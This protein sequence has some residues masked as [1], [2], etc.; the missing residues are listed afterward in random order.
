MKVFEPI[1]ING[2][3]LANRF[4]R[5]ATW[6]AMATED[7]YCTPELTEYL[8]R[9]A[10]GGVGLIISGHSNISP[11]GKAGIKQL[12]IW[13]DD[14]I[15]ELSKMTTLVHEAGGRIFMQLNHAGIR[16]A[17]ELTGDAPMGPTLYEKDDGS[18][19]RE[20]TRLDISKVT[21]D[22]AQAALRAK[23]AGFDGIQVHAAH[24]YL[25]SSFL[26]PYFNKRRDEYGGSVENR[27]RFLLET[28][29]A[30][31]ALT[32]DDF[33]VTI[34]MNA[35]D[36]LP[37][38]FGDRELLETVCLLEEGGVDA[39]ELSGGTAFSGKN[40]P[41]RQGKL[42]PDKEGYYKD[43]A[44]KCKQKLAIPVMLVGGIRSLHIAEKFLQ[45][46][47][48]DIISLCRP[49]I[50]EPELINR[51]RS[52]D[53]APAA[54]LSDNL[55]YRPVREGKSLYCVTKERVGEKITGK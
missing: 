33:P 16:T 15:P 35:S 39:I 26:S 48:C 40:I 6:E 10:K 20:M 30:V 34:K 3:T 5:S 23:Q 25:L 53:D 24:G 9:V 54:C 31:F 14:F 29:Q 37:G 28:L 38:G 27:A 19:S 12:A 42:S 8:L 2:L 1:T 46:G 45:E 18:F 51:W 41:S 43:E 36:F 52:G 7:G 4:V 11:K 55:C 13:Q 50:N 47:V 17:T 49:L 44:A 22:F 21:D 32:G